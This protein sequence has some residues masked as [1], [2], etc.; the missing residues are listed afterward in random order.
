M[1]EIRLSPTAARTLAKL[2]AAAR[3]RIMAKLARY[4]AEPEKV[5]GSVKALKGSDFLRLRVDDYR[6]IFR[7]GADRIE[8]SKVG[9]RRD[10]YE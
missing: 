5:A 6:V 9:H 3:G 7:E 10:V 8:V 2:P 4:A 1:K